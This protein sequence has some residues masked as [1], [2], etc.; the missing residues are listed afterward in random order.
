MA[1][2][3]RTIDP[4]AGIPAARRKRF[5]ALLETGEAF[6]DVP[7]EEIEREVARLTEEDRAEQRARRQPAPERP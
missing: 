2:K 3:E 6:K 1:R 7:P 4:L 5:R